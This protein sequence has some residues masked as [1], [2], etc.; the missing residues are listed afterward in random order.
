[1]TKIDERLVD[2]QKQLSNGV[3]MGNSLAPQSC[4]QGTTNNHGHHQ[5]GYYSNQNT[6]T[7]FVYDGICYGVPKHFQFP[8]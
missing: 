8:A 3:H 6:V 2:M 1:M 5:D 4:E 7:T